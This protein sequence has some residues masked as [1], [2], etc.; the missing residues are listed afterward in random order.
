MRL[1]A[2]VST[3]ARA[4][5]DALA[6]SVWQEDIRR[7]AI[8]AEDLARLDRDAHGALSAAVAR[9][10]MKGE[11]G[12][13]V[14]AA[15]RGGRI[16]VFL[17]MGKRA[18]MNPRAWLILGAAA[19]HF[20]REHRVKSLA[21][22]ARVEGTGEIARLLAQGLHLGG[23]EYA[24]GTGEKFK[25]RR[26][27]LQSAV[28]SFLSKLPGQVTEALRAGSIVG[29]AANFARDLVNEP[30]NVVTP[31]ELAARAKAWCEPA[32]VEVDVWGKAKLK[33]LNCGGLLGVNQGSTEP[34]V[35]IVMRH[36]P[37][38]PRGGAKLALV[39]KGVTFDTGG[40]SL[41]P[42]ADMHLMKGDMAGAAAVIAAMGAIGRLRLPV[43]VIAY[44]PST[45]NM[46]S[47]SAIRPGDVVTHPNG[48]T[49]E[50]LN[51]DAEGR[52]ILADALVHACREKPTHL[53]DWATLTGACVVALGER[54]AG[55]MSP[56]EAWRAR[57]CA[58]GADAGERVWPLPLDE[59]FAE[60]L[61]K[62]D[63]ADLANIGGGRWGGA[64]VAGKFLEQ[65]VDGPLWAHVDIAGPSYA[66]SAH[67]QFTT[68]GATGCGVPLAVRLA[69]S[70]AAERGG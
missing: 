15:T 26:P 42:G 32:G 11:R 18:K 16:I 55:V 22:A 25:R 4:P 61:K 1:S 17:G 44:V 63:V 70:L 7:R 46:P 20:A 64:E 31:T 54:I 56:D 30:A 65:F 57:V 58:L 68:K 3:P 60:G 45:D 36:A 59:D 50:V 14:E 38:E 8:V 34:P 37:E 33:A 5:G 39:G 28:I 35:M 48:K 62:S 6:V 10:S 2:T 49:T 21:L 51:T 24:L 19:S 9:E 40:I 12:Q 52:L 53:V 66:S 41:K 69:E 67:A 27:P 13:R 47:G 23:Y 29:Q 43:Q